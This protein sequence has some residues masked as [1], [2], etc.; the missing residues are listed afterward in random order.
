MERYSDE[1]HS[2][3]YRARLI[4]RESEINTN[5]G[6]TSASTP[7][8]GTLRLEIYYCASRAS[9]RYSLFFAEFASALLNA[10]SD[11]PV[12]IA[13]PRGVQVRDVYCW[14]LKRALYGTESAPRLLHK[15]LESFC[16]N[17]DSFFQSL[18]LVCNTVMRRT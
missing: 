2:E 17:L 7:H 5:L 11:P 8:L 6:D 12:C 1:T 13:P 16:I 18:T 10:I 15:T 4:V 14:R 3:R 9:H